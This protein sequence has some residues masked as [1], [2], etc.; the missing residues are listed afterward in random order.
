MK[1]TGKDPDSQTVSEDLENQI[2]K[3]KHE[4]NQ[5]TKDIAEI[6]NSIKLL[7]VKIE[8]LDFEF[9]SIILKMKPTPEILA[10]PNFQINKLLFQELVIQNRELRFEIEKL[11][12]KINELNQENQNIK[13]MYK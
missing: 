6:D 4:Q 8:D 5:V 3:V 12:D 7:D 9:Q 2:K 13:N 11:T 1:E 10:D